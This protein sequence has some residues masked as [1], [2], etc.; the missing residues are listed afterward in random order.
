VLRTRVTRLPGLERL[1]AD[2]GYAGK[3]VPWVATVLQR[4]LVMVQRPRHPQ[5]VQGLPW[6]WSVARTCGWLKRSRRLSKDF[7]AWPETT[8]TW[9]RSAMIHLMVRRLAARA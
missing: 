1:W 3:L 4:A 5:G 9:I 6:R 7:E 2:G 8:E